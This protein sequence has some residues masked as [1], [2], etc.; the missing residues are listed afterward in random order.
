[1]RNTLFYGKLSKNIYVRGSKE[2]RAKKSTN[3]NHLLTTLVLPA[4][5]ARIPRI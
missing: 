3:R 1:M 2:P 4:A 5:N